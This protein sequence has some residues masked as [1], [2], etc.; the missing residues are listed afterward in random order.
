MNML[1][2][3]NIM[4]L[5]PAASPPSADQQTS[6]DSSGRSVLAGCRAMPDSRSPDLQDDEGAA[7]TE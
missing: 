5:W 6:H 7:G 1:I 3:I 2:D 4:I